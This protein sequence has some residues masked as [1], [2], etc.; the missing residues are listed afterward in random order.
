LYEGKQ[1]DQFLIDT[2]PMERWVNLETAEKTNR[3]PEA[4]PKLVFR[5]IASNTN[6]RTCIAAV[7]PSGSCFGHTLS[8]LKTESNIQAISTV[9]N[10]FV[11]DYALRFRTA[12]THLSFTYLSRMPLPD[13]LPTKCMKTHSSN[14]QASHIMDDKK[15][16]EGLVV[17]N[18]E[19]LKA[20]GLTKADLSHILKAF[21][22]QSRKRAEFMAYL[23]GK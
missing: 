13:F 6:E 1:I 15:H 20:Y 8:G 2:K 16:W 3:K 11:F 12:G 4:G 7:L 17:S 21:P 19:V 18:V 23:Q 22:V 10:S 14:G 5:D 9:L